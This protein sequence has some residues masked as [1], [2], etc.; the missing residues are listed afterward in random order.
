MQDIA[1]TTLENTAGRLKASDVEALAAGIRGEVL[2]PSGLD[3][4]AQMGLGAALDALPQKSVAQMALYR[5][6]FFGDP[7]FTIGPEVLRGP[8]YWTPAEREYFAVFTSRLNECPFCVRIHT[9]TTR[10]ESGG[11]ID[12]NDAMSSSPFA[13]SRGVPD[14]C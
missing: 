7:M 3:A 10:V 4:I 14:E 8:S 2:M 9:E 1:Y 6:E 5:P 13:P 11:A 12:V